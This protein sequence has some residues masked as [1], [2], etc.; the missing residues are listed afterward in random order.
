MDERQ[1]RQ[2]KASVCVVLCC[3]ALLP[4]LLLLHSL[5]LVYTLLLC[6]L[7]FHAHSSVCVCEIRVT[8]TTVTST[9]C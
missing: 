3:S 7:A 1:G 8:A 5:P 2:R 4:T 6:V 9:V